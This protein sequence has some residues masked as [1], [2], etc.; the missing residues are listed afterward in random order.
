MTFLKSVAAAL[1]VA[2]AMSGIAEAQT[3]APGAP[4][5]Q[6]AGVLSELAR[7]NA[8]IAK[9]DASIAQDEAALEEDKYEA[10]S[11]L[12]D[13]GQSDRWP[14]AKAM[15]KQFDLESERDT[16]EEV[17]AQR[18]S[19]AALPPCKDAPPP[20]PPPKPPCRTPAQDARLDQI[21]AEL[22]SV[23]AQ[24]VAALRGQRK[25]P[26]GT[27][28][29]SEQYDKAEAAREKA[30]A[31]IKERNAIEALPPCP[32]TTP[33]AAKPVPPPLERRDVPAPGVVNPFFDRKKGPFSGLQAA[34]RSNQGGG[35]PPEFKFGKKQPNTTGHDE[36]PVTKVG[37][38]DRFEP[39]PPSQAP[40]VEEGERPQIEG[41]PPNPPPLPVDPGAIGMAAPTPLEAAVLATLNFAREHPA[42]FALRLE[43]LP[44]SA[45]VDAAIAFVRAQPPLPPLT[46]QPVL[47]A[48]AR[49]HAIEQG[50]RGGWGHAGSDGSTPGQRM[51]RAGVFSTVSAEI[52]SYGP[53]TAEGVVEQ[54]ILEA[55]H[56]ADV[57]AKLLHDAGVGCGPN[58]AYKWECVIDMT[59]GAA[60]GAD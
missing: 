42:E 32:N 46:G 37:E 57:F 16:L 59:A 31:L 22:K 27:S 40:E 38:M 44:R 36:T 10:G 58:T 51:Q 4:A 1:A 29:W 14:Q 6:D 35:A 11:I 43:K 50:P 23:Q 47:F 13:P 41:P 52:I 19:L 18:D 49:A 20:P 12:L 48:V 7:L 55:M 17:T 34:G 25:A 26:A 56:R 5:C 33:N 53:T 3:Q 2:C 28:Y 60:V 24:A 30:I 21:E 8:E 45:A 39:E 15:T 54:E 9:I